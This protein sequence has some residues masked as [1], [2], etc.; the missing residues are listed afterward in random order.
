MTHDT[1]SPS[2]F[3]R[4]C[5]LRSVWYILTVLCD[6]VMCDWQL[7]TCD[8][9]AVGKLRVATCFQ[10]VCAALLFCSAVSLARGS[11]VRGLTFGDVLRWCCVVFSGTKKR[12]S[13]PAPV[14]KPES[15]IKVLD[16]H[17]D[18]EHFEWGP[19]GVRVRGREYVLDTALWR[20]LY[21]PPPTTNTATA[22]APA[23]PK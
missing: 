5:L 15:D 12:K 4:C 21:P 17:L 10:I 8:G 18:W 7:V 13:D 14:P 23:S 2:L 11:V 1:A 20:P 6:D 22:A 16:K 3:C 19:H 9:I